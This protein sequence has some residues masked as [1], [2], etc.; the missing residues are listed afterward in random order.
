MTE[1]NITSVVAKSEDKTIQISFTVP[2]PLIKKAQDE[3]LAE[4][5]KDTEIPGFR[6]GKAPL[7]KVKE[8]IPADILIQKSLAKILPPALAKAIEEHKIKPAIYPKFELLSAKENE[9]WQI[10]ATTCEL[11][12]I[13]LPDYKTK[14]K[15][16]SIKTLKEPAKEEKEQ[17]AIKILLDLVKVT[18]PRL[19]VSEEVDARLSSLLSRIEK[20]GLSLEGYLQSIGK[21]PE[22]LRA[23]YELQAKNTITLELILNEISVIEKIKVEEGEIDGAIKAAAADTK[24]AEN[25]NTPEQRRLIRSVLSRRKTLDYLASLV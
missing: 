2:F 3:V 10:R 14:I 22:T 18:L 23:E 1:P 19:L 12:Q 15:E 17:K 24:L 11:P 7:E 16:Q 20:L 8:K 21:T 25:L 13:I 5:A 9:N 4:S 6:K